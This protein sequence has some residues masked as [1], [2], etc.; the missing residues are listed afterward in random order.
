MVNLNVGTR[1]QEFTFVDKYFVNFSV[2]RDGL[3]WSV[4]RLY[5]PDDAQK[6]RVGPRYFRESSA[7]L[8]MLELGNAYVDG[9]LNRKKS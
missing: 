9:T 5:G 3:M 8:A 4:Y 1:G 7:R 6:T 2:E